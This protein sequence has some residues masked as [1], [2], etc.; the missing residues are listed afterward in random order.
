MPE[1]TSLAN[2]YHDLVISLDKIAEHYFYE[3]RLQDAINL[4]D[5]FKKNTNYEDINPSD[6][7]HLLVSYGNQL[8]N[9]IFALSISIDDVLAVLTEASDLIQKLENKEFH[10]ELIYLFG[11]AHY[12]DQLSKQPANFSQAN[13]YLIEARAIFTKINDT[14]HLSMT[15]LFLGLIQ[16][17]T[18]N[19]PE[20][21]ELFI[22]GNQLAEQNNHLFE[23][24]YTTR[25]IGMLE[26]A[27]GNLETAHKYLWQ[28]LDLRLK[29]GFK[30]GLPFSYIALGDVLGKQNSFEDAKTH[31]TQA[32][33][34]ANSMNQRRP[35]LFA[36]LS[37]GILHLEQGNNLQAKVHLQT[38]ELLANEIEHAGAL[39]LI[40]TKLTET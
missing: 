10:A 4:L 18:D 31:Y 27:A 32:I 28:S 12:Y 21:M 26:N 34:L 19:A 15:L 1:Q 3:G 23:Q 11:V 33:E 13:E 20:A 16:Q 2:H 8:V 9:G 14:R 6:L 7:A 29:V 5:S 22:E 25:H 30:N 35:L 38:A 24:S 39:A 17:F 36:T 37:M 40:K